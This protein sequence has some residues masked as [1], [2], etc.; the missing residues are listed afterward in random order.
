MPL[1]GAQLRSQLP[2]S[3]HS[4]LEI[5]WC[6]SR[7]GLAPS[8]ECLIP[9]DSTAPVAQPTGSYGCLTGECRGFLPSPHTPAPSESPIMCFPE[10]P[11]HTLTNHPCSS[12]LFPPPQWPDPLIPPRKPQVGR[13]REAHPAPLCPTPPQLTQ[14]QQPRWD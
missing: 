6:T 7:L 9:V 11:D 1:P 8:P 13:G 4:P 3:N 14:S 5:P 12:S 2:G 10:G